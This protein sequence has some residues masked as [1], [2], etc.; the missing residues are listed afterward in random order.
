ML[1]NVHMPDGRV[2]ASFFLS[3]G[4]FWLY[5]PGALA[6]RHLICIVV[7]PVDAIIVWSIGL[8]GTS[9]RLFPSFFPFLAWYGY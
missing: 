5:W 1:L 9:V 4:F 3:L 8:L 6:A 7:E 2:S